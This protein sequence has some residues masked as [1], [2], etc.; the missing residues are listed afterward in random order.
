M[1]NVS[2][3]SEPDPSHGEEE[4]S[5]HMC[6]FNLSPERNVDLTNQ[7]NIDGMETIYFPV[8]LPTRHSKSLCYS[9]THECGTKGEG[10]SKQVVTVFVRV[11]SQLIANCPRI[12]VFHQDNL[13]VGTCPD[14]S[15]SPCER[16]GSD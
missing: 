3:D 10:S 5:G 2:E 11:V 8:S 4:E 12:I 13:N 6:S 9:I 14:P 1:F 15:S 7:V 16:S